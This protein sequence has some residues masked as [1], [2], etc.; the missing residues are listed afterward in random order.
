MSTP[1]MKAVRQHCFGDPQVLR[2]EEAPRP[3]VA[4]GE[5]LVRVHAVGLNPP[6]LYL[7]EGYR[8][9]PEAW[10]PPVS[11]PLILGT[12]VSGVVVD[13]AD[14][15]EGFAVGD[16]VL[17]MV[18]FP[19]GLAGGSRAYAD[20]VSV[21]AGDLAPKPAGL[22]HLHAAA[23]PMSALTA[24]QFLVEV[25]HDAVNPLQAR[26]HEPVPLAGRTV[27]V[28][29]AAG[30]VGHLALQIAKR[31]GARVLAAASARH[32]ALLRDLG[33]DG[34]IDYRKTPPEDVVRGVDLVVD[35]VGGPQTG[36]FLRTLKPG[37]ALFPVFPL[38]FSG[39]AEADRL[40]VTVSTT[41]VRS[42]G[43][44]LAHIARLVANG[45]IHVAI[46]SLYPLAAASEAHERAGRGH[47]Q[48]KIVLTV[49]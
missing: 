11:F 2:L 31:Q 4:P 48:G 18:R 27:L 9:L 23:A 41:Q 5:V 10:R 7:R 26:P 12:D 19:E 8:M 29:G 44:Q 24:W 1:M 46:D 42:N 35:T 34:I 22:D 15:V 40:G 37:G 28:N 32:A 21:P 43:A 14:D 38:G 36:R 39:A 17:A 30:G 25:G 16:E 45:T 20:H 49:S 3:D 6:D 33:A 13:V 47:V